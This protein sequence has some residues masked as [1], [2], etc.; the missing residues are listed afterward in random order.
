MTFEVYA[1]VD[2]FELYCMLVT[3]DCFEITA[4]IFVLQI[5][6]CLMAHTVRSS[7]ILFLVS[8]LFGGTLYDSI[9]HVYFSNL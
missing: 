8:S 5:R 3:F 7:S 2:Y 1:Y 4:F 6:R 9:R